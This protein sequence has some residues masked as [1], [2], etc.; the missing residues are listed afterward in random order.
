MATSNTAVAVG[1][2]SSTK[3]EVFAKGADGQMR[4]LAVGDK[5]FEGE[6]IVT[7]NGSSVEINMFNG[8]ALHVAEQQSVTVDNQVISHAH[9][10]TAGAISS[11]GS[12][13]AAKVIQTVNTGDAQDFNK[14]LDDQATAAGLTG[15]DGGGGHGFVDL[16]RLVENVPTSGY[17]FP[18]NPSGAS[19]TIQTLAGA[20]TDTLTAQISIDPIFGNNVINNQQAQ[21][22]TTTITGTVT[23]VSTSTVNA[24]EIV[25]LT[26]N[27]TNYFGTVVQNPTTGAL[28][29]SIPVNTSDLVAN[30]TTH[31]ISVSVTMTDTG[32]NTSAS[33]ATSTASDTPMLD[34]LT[35][36]ITIASVPVI[37]NTELTGTST[38]TG[39]VTASGNSSIKAGE[40]VTLTAADGHTY[41]GTLV[42]NTTTGELT[43]SIGG[44]LNSDL[45]SD[46]TGHPFTVSVT[47][48][49]A[50]GSQYVATNTVTPTVDVLTAQISVDP[51]AAI[52]NTELTSTSTITG[53]ITASGNSSVSAGETVTLTAADGHTY[54]GVVIQNAMTGALT[55]SISGVSNADL[56]TN[57]EGQ[58]FSVSV[59][60][61]DANGSQLAISNT[62]TPTVDTLTAQINVDPIIINN[63]ELTGST[64]VTGEISA[65]GSSKVTPGETVTLTAADGHTYTGVVVQDATTGALTYSISGVSNADLVTNGEGQPFTVSVTMTDANGSQ[66][67]ASNTATTTGDA[68]TAQITVDPIAV[69][70]NMELA[71]T[72]TITGTVTSTNGNTINPGETVTL[73][74][75][76]GHTY[77]GLVIQDGTTGALTYSISGVSNADLVT[78]GTGQP[79]TVSVT[80]T[81]VNGSQFAATNTVTPAGDTLSAGISVDSMPVINNTELA[82]TTTVT[83]TV[84]AIGNSSI[85]PGET[86]TLTA[87]DGHTYTGVVVQ[88]GTTGALTYSI[89]G[90]S[91]ADLVTNGVGNPF[92]VSVTMSDANGSQYVASNT[93]T[94]PTDT[95]TAQISVDSIPVINNTELAGTTTVTGEISAIGNS[96]VNPGETVTLT[97][98]DGH[99]YAGVVVQDATTGALTYSISGVSNADLVTNGVGQPFTVSVTMS[100]ANGSQFATTN[101]TTPIGDVLTAQATIDPIIINNQNLGSTATTTITGTVSATGSSS[102]NAG[103]S[104]S[105]TVNGNTYT[106]VVTEN[107]AHTGLV[108]SVPNVLNTDLVA[109]DGSATNPVTVS[110]TMSDTNQSQAVASA[111]AVPVLDTLSASITVDSIII[112]NQNLD[113]AATS[114]ITGTLTPS[115]TGA[116]A[117]VGDIVS[118][119]VNGHSYSGNVIENAQGALTYSVTG[120]PNSDL[121]APDGSASQVQISVSVIDANGS[122]ATATATVS[123]VLDTLSTSVSINPIII[124]NQSLDPAATTTI[125]GTLSPTGTG[126]T[127][128][129]GD[130]VTL[131]AADGHVYQ[132]TVIQGANGLTYSVANVLNSDLASP[133]GSATSP[134]TVSVAMT[135]TNGSQATASATAAPLLDTLSTSVSIDPI[136]INNS[137]LDPAATTTITGTLS[138]TGTGATAIV[139][140][141]V[142]LTAADGHVYQGTVIQGANGLTYSVANVLNSD[143]VSL[144]GSATSPVTVSVA[145]TDTNGS[146]ATA[147]S[148]V[149]PVLETLNAGITINTTS[150]PVIHNADLSGS[151]TITGT[152]TETVV[153]G[154]INAGETVTLTAADGNSYTGTVVQG[155]N[156]L[157]YSIAG[158]ANNDLIGTDG[159]AQTFTVSTAITDSNGNSVPVSTS[160]AVTA[161]TLSAGIT[162]DATS[163]P[164]IHNADLSGSSTITGT[165]TETV[166]GGTINAGETVTLTAAD[167]NSYT[168]TVV[169]GTNGLTY[170]IAGVANNDLIG[171]D[172]TAQTFTV[173]TAITDSNGNSVPV[174][175]TGAATADTLTAAINVDTLP[176]LLNPDLSASTTITG[177]ITDT[178]VGGSINAGETVTL[179]AADN[180]TYT[181]TV[182]Q[183]TSTGALTYSIAGVANSDLVGSDGTAQAFTV[184]TTMTDS[185]GNSVPV[186]T[187]GAVTADTLTAGITVDPIVINNQELGLNATSTITGTLSPT[188]SGAS[189][190][191]GDLVTL[192]TVNGNSYN[193]VVTQDPNTGALTY[194]VSGVSNADLI[195]PDGSATNPVTVTVAMTDLSGSQASASA[196]STPVLDVLNTNIAVDPIIINNQELGSASTITGTLSPSGSGANALVGDSVTLTTV[197]G[198]SYTGTVA[199]DPTT[200]ALTYSVSGVSNA[201]LVSPDGSAT[202]P[203]TVTV[204]MTDASGSQATAT[205]SVSPV[206]DTL[207]AGITVDPIII[208]NQELGLNATSTITGTLSPTGSGS[209][210]LVGD[211]VTLTVNGSS[212]NGVVTQDPITGA[213]TYSV[214]GVSN[215]DLVSPDGS[216][217]N[218]VTVT[219]A[220]SDA[221]GSQASSFATASPL[222]DMLNAQIIIHPIAIN[223]DHSTASTTTISGIVS[224]SNAGTSIIHDGTIT[225]TIGTGASAHV[226]TGVVVQP[227]MTFSTNVSTSWLSNGTPVN[228][229]ITVTDSG[230]SVASATDTIKTSGETDSIFVAGNSNSG[231]SSPSFHD[232]G[233]G[234]YTIENDPGNHGNNGN[235]QG[236]YTCAPGVDTIVLSHT[237]SGTTNMYSEVS[238][239]GT[240]DVLNLKDILSNGGHIKSIET[241]T[242]KTTADVCITEG[243]HSDI[244]HIVFDSALSGG[245]KL[246]VD[247]SSHLIKIT[248]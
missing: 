32:G 53:T 143:L 142:T 180:H 192:T 156:G 235:Q 117:V 134:V 70:N 167:G 82:G 144:N 248:G 211:I 197:N 240:N 14:V 218:P 52:N 215:A 149:S 216:A 219:V 124:N 163:L 173:S 21:Q 44:V 1:E 114:T 100:D 95:L 50:N 97:A 140:D 59:T 69:I 136:I 28:T 9:D 206:L 239:F 12:T 132:G 232:N 68:L 141:T 94:P 129:V 89:N 23:A 112:N 199:Q 17:N 246:T 22:P 242:D 71:G 66:Y 103:E 155:T 34:T 225:L 60:M 194:S 165:I 30:G 227:D 127:A 78:N 188:G 93:V 190:L 217:T 154:T 130:T 115:G 122:Q 148:T 65:V 111:T 11:I 222:L 168:G 120:V 49:D 147:S 210:A 25:T 42:Q 205:A 35:A 202:N 75:A 40:T 157:T 151:S 201:D 57:A 204:A 24:G 51:I 131:T 228:A 46:G 90:V 179:T 171:T 72:S 172:G 189:A 191:A 10:A 85:N 135:D 231:H 45:V 174:S 178:V 2:V 62:V 196:T 193:G 241:S 84:S 91:N 176:T 150:L 55:Y 5:I 161:D 146:Q 166:V 203:V 63:T 18:S 139:G 67:V 33:Q 226:I 118:L 237:N 234:T 243:N 121:A 87:A 104:I 74:A 116:N 198:N 223:D 213:L 224:A 177:T 13:E 64:T 101:T 3:G 119:T 77:T 175:T 230:G 38:V 153:G 162:I 86:V 220:I 185:N 169:Q 7:A 164:V 31:A 186:S 96:K 20:P 6:V 137:S 113:P 123:P 138:P 37:N 73:T 29:Y 238:K 244:I 58:P 221:S 15:G 16:V 105:L 41:T 208:N 92:T 233:N 212:Y 181:G 200:G 170:S 195:S 27:G 39:T 99:T 133:D 236:F 102:I 83:G 109:P 245:Q 8:P 26:V 214:S 125:T 43:Y 184:S 54:T 145:M 47:V 81:D 36:H 209:G 79:F 61:T 106:G 159:T 19:P 158:V 152:I 107:S 98:A 80:V 56:V 187:T 108:Y 160:G 4:R 207:S 229:S 76:D 182:V 48:T 128:I 183:D 110:I 126:A 88:D 247:S